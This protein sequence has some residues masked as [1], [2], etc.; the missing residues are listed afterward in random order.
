MLSQLPYNGVDINFHILFRYE[1]DRNIKSGNRTSCGKQPSG[2]GESHAVSGHGV[3][4]NVFV[5]LG[6]VKT[7]CE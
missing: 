2:K 3:C 5:F 4:L 6:D 7:Y 1:N